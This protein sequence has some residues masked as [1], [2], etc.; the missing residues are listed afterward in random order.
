MSSAPCA[1]VGLTGDADLENSRAK[2]PGMGEEMLFWGEDWRKVI[3]I[4][5]RSGRDMK[6]ITFR[7]VQ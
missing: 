6:L 2:G 5:R 7:S 1:G 3:D 4:L